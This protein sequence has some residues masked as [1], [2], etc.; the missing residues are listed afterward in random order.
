MSYTSTNTY[1]T[2]YILRPSLTEANAG[3]VNAKVDSVIDKFSGKIKAK[4]DWGLRELAYPIEKETM[5]RY[6]IVVYTGNSGVVE[7]VERHFKISNDVMRFLTVAVP[8]DYDYEASKKA[9]VLAEEELR[10]IREAKKKGP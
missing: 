3:A 10:K 9:I 4:D 5:G 7:E 2:V 8:A 1:E 6:N